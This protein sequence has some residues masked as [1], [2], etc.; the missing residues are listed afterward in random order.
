MKFPFFILFSAVATVTF[1]TSSPTVM[2][3]FCT[4]ITKLVD[5]KNQTVKCEKAKISLC[6]IKLMYIAMSLLGWISRTLD[7]SNILRYPL[8]FELTGNTGKI[9]V[10]ERILG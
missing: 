10:F 8:K 7:S 1:A 9:I 3:M 5:N 6:K 2:E 4:K